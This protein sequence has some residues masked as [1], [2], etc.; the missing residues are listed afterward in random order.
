MAAQVESAHLGELVYFPLWAKGLQ[1]SI[2]AEATALATGMKTT[3]T[4]VNDWPA[5]KESGVCPF[6]QLPI[7]KTPEGLVLG[8]SVAIANYLGR[9]GDLHGTNDTE[10]A[11]S[12]MCMCEGE[13]IF[14]K[15]GKLELAC[16][17]SPEDRASVAEERNE[18]FAT[19]LPMHLANLEKLCSQDKGFTSSGETCGELYLW[20]MLHQASRASNDADASVFEGY[21]KL[22]AW[23]N[24]LHT[25]HP[26]VLKVTTGESAWKVG[27][28]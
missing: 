13:D 24:R 26:A 6:S 7:F 18:F 16:W 25:T 12:Q 22:H 9:K 10:F 4:M 27:Y 1:V 28:V 3:G 21:P 23:F 17:K 5:L 19:T 14:G 20:G 8:Q 2:I 15:L 11:I